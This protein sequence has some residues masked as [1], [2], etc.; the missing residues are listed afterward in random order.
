V[1]LTAVAAFTA[2]GLSLVNVIVTYRLNRRARLD[3]WRRNEERP[4]VA[5]LL[6]LSAEASREWASTGVEKM[7]AHGLPQEK[8]DAAYASVLEHFGKG[9]EL[10]ESAN[11]EV[12]QLDL[13][14]GPRVREAAAELVKVHGTAAFRVN[15]ASGR[16]GVLPSEELGA[17]A[18]LHDRLVEATRAD[19]GAG[20]SGGPITRARRRWRQPGSAVEEEAA[21]WLAQLKAYYGARWS[22][23]PQEPGGTTFVAVERTTG[24]RILD[25][26]VGLGDQIERYE[27][28][29]NRAGP[30]PS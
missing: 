21:D 9:R 11:Y 20:I 2:A 6:R 14:A 1:N 23:D 28:G 27:D 30:A 15:P 13:L 19:T 3:E 22:I 24:H 12:A 29:L 4:I 17:I 7:Q 25:S 8:R 26:L 16:R 10:L 18:L 5:R